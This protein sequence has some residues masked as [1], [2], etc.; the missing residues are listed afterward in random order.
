MNKIVLI[1]GASR[2]IGLE[3]AKIFAKSGYQV[4]GTSRSKFD[5]DDLIKNT[6]AKSFQLDLMSKSSIK[7]LF[8]NL[9]NENL[10]VADRNNH[11]I[12]IIYNFRNLK[13]EN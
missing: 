7:E 8:S 4:I 10:Y 11:R 13:F 5:L 9:K 1:T 6:D 2:G 3:T 12:K